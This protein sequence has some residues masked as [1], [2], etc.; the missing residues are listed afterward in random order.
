MLNTILSR[1]RAHGMASA[2]DTKLSFKKR[3]ILKANLLRANK[4]HVQL[5]FIIGLKS[6]ACVTELVSARRLC[7]ENALQCC[8]N[9]LNF[10]AIG[11]HSFV[12]CNICC[13]IH[14]KKVKRKIVINEQLQIFVISL[15]R[16][17]NYVI[18]LLQ[19]KTK[20]K[21]KAAWMIISIW[22]W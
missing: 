19:T 13:L 6:T 21:P 8:I 18:W 20:T 2:N 5:C 10:S 12:D 16:N 11:R 14:Q 1:H 9:A 7:T 22:R 17:D 15:W 3:I 4:N